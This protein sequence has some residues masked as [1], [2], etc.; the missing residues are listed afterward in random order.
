MITWMQKHKK[1]LV[2]TIWVSTIA[3]VGAGFVGWGAYDFNKS[4]ATSVAKV[5]DTDITMTKFQSMYSQMHSFYSQALG[6]NLSEEEADKMGLSEAAINRLIQETLLLNYA[7][8]LG[9]SVSDDE[10]IAEL[11]KTPTFQKN[12][13]FDTATYQSSLKALRITHT[14]YE[15]DIK[16]RL[17][18]AKLFGAIELK[19]DEQTARILASDMLMSDT[20]SA[21]IISAPNIEPSEDEI[22]TSWEKS[23]NLYLTPLKHELGLHFVPAAKNDASDDELK[24]FYEENRGDYRDGEDKILEFQDAK[25][26]VSSDYALKK[27]KKT[28]LEEYVKVK[29]AEIPTE[30]I[31]EITATD[32]KGLN[33]EEIKKAKV[34]DVL[35]PMEYNGGYAIVKINKIINPEPKSYEAAK[36]EAKKSLIAIKQ[37]EELEN[38]AKKELEN[39]ATMELSANVS[40]GDNGALFNLSLEQTAALVNKVFAS[41]AKKGYIVF[42]ENAV[43]YEIVA[44]KL[45]DEEKFSKFKTQIEQNAAGLK[46]AQ[47]ENALVNSLAKRY[48][49]EKYY[50]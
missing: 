38:L 35:K 20:I 44:Q 46:S 43:V 8:E 5:G 23:K 21:K 10:V 28:A 27:A 30:E 29:K 22:K 42:D 39:N 15:N 48:K 37:K 49:I 36:D 45:I 19:S 2:V 26:A 47:M 11:V 18:L 33:Y 25:V 14:A 34:G 6:K 31:I 1:Y 32:A 17:L 13:K 9:L 16:D 3:F 7:K 24:A 50:K 40:K 12:G 41:G 4:R